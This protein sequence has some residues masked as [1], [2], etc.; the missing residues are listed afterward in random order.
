MIHCVPT[1]VRSLKPFDIVAAIRYYNHMEAYQLR[2]A[3]LQPDEVEVPRE[4]RLELLQ[5]HREML[6]EELARVNEEIGELEA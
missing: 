2:I 1:F 5:A 4:K 3:R 6:R